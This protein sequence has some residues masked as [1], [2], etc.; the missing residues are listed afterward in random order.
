MPPPSAYQR[1][2]NCVWCLV[3]E[4]IRE[5]AEP[6]AYDI[7]GY[8][9]RSIKTVVQVINWNL[10]RTRT[11]C[12]RVHMFIAYSTRL[13][14][15]YMMSDS[16]FGARSSWPRTNT[17]IAANVLACA[18]N[19]PRRVAGSLGSLWILGFTKLSSLYIPEFFNFSI[20]ISL[21]EFSNFLRG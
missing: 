7:G 4:E 19:F 13:M 3:C 20:F 5:G 10:P 21:F 17:H 14:P 11:S 2:R 12:A 8:V 15:V 6:A 16:I 9:H 1:K 18:R